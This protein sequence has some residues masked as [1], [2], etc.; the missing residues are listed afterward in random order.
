MDLQFRTHVITPS[1]PRIIAGT[2][3]VVGVPGREGWQ[4][5]AAHIRENLRFRSADFWETEAIRRYLHSD[6]ISEQI[7]RHW[8][9][10]RVEPEVRTFTDK[11]LGI[12]RS[13][14]QQKALDFILG[15]IHMGKPFPSDQAIADH[16]GW[17]RRKSAR[18]MLMTLSGSG[19]LSRHRE[20]GRW[21]FTFEKEK[22]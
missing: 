2:A 15:E 4:F 22:A 12:T 17:Q 13:P 11:P 5:R 14:Q 7:T 21:V 9:R 6:S 8:I 16:M 20:K 1:G 18:D 19:P 10:M 3:E